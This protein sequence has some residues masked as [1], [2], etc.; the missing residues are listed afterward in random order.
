MHEL[1]VVAQARAA[2]HAE[3]IHRVFP[4][5]AEAVLT[6][7]L[8]ALAPLDPAVMEV[9]FMMAPLQVLMTVVL[10]VAGVCMQPMPRR[11][12]EIRPI[13][14]RPPGL[15]RERPR[16]LLRASRGLDPFSL[17]VEALPTVFPNLLGLLPRS[18]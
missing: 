13:A 11:L 8:F 15:L 10:A 4:R 2:L 1:A 6:P 5:V 14:L 18:F 12:E 16:V 17:D 3:L 9:A 7:S